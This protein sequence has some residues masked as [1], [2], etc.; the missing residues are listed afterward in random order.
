[1]PV[2]EYKAVD[3]DGRTQVG[4]IDA[5]TPFEGRRKLRSQELYVT[6]IAP[7][8]RK[9]D[10]RA[11]TPVGKALEGIGRLVKYVFTRT[12][13]AE[14]VMMTRQFATLV[15][16][17][18][19]VVQSL[20]ALVE[21]VQPG[22]LQQALN[23]TRERVTQG[24][25]LATALEEHPRF[26]SSLYVNMVRA[27]EASG[28]LDQVLLRLADYTQKQNHVRAKVRSAFTYPAMLAVFGTGVVIF[29]L[30]HVL[31]R[32]VNTLVKKG[33]NLPL[34][35]L[36]LMA[37]SDF[38]AGYWW[39]LATA[40][41][42]AWLLWRWF[43]RTPRGRQFRDTTKLRMPILGDLFKKRAIAQ[44]AVTFST[45]LKS[46][47]P[48]VESLRIVKNI[49]NNV[50]LQR[51]IE[52]LEQS[53][54]DGTD[55][56]GPLKA[57]GVFPPVVS[58]MVAVGEETG[59]LEDILSKVAEAYD[60]EVDVATTRLTSLLEPALIIVMAFIVGFIVLSIMM[61]IIQRGGAF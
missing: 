56:A 16:S 25:P 5:A 32:I 59:R 27:G 21:Q 39:L 17:G 54:I 15:D 11:E 18:I 47:L 53:I 51:T 57:S 28:N 8:S 1:M 44:F 20:E 29:L 2:Y 48:V 12:K 10:S 52:D 30:T 7:A 61:P 3:A 41:I 45:L 9:A 49:V 60:E 43:V 36:M 4:I 35:T 19:P 38:L 50:I 31:P 14:F 37:T 58:Y 46:G 42:G 24:A 40:G 26:F 13:P 22:P 6:E 34:P 33:V 23:A 55:I